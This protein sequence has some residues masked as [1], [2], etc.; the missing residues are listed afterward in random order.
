VVTWSEWSRR[1]VSRHFTALPNHDNANTP[2]VVSRFKLHPRLPLLLEKLIRS[3]KAPPTPTSAMD[4]WRLLVADRSIMSE[5]GFSESEVDII[6]TH[7]RDQQAQ[8]DRRLER[9]RSAEPWLDEED[10]AILLRAWQLRVGFLKQKGGSEIRYS[11]LALDEAQDFAAMEIAVLM[12]TLDKYRCITLAGDTQQHIQDVGGSTDWGGLLENLGIPSTSLSTLKISYRSTRPITAFCRSIL[13]NLAED[14]SPPLTTRDGPPVE[15]FPFPDHGACVEF[16]GRVLK[17]LVRAEPNAS[18][19]LITPVIELTRTYYRGLERM[20]IPNLRIV[21]DQEFAFAPGVDVVDVSQ[22]K[23]L[24]FDYVVVI[25]ASYAFYPER[26]HTRRQLHVAGTR[27]IHQLW[28]TSVGEP[29]TSLSQ[30]IL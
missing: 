13:G 26:P 18:I 28:I 5:L 4:D 14:D 7:C 29:S 15:I 9:D 17:N 27:A 25:E 19:A 12:G 11:H 2:A 6:A 24:E 8:L 1:L 10:D 21:E 20:E 22:V 3:R 16:L 23:G 30:E